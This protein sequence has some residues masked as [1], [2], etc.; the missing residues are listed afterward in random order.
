MAPKYFFA[1]ALALLVVGCA[2]S[3]PEAD[4]PFYE[5]GFSDGCASANAETTPIPRNPQRDETL[6]AQDSGYR[7]G[8]ISGH[9]ACLMQGGAARL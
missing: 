8:W 6:Y 9:A 3:S 5:V 7:S 2:A 4:S 1:A